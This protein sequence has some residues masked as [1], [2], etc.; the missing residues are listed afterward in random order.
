[1]YSVAEERFNIASHATGLVL[2]V[3]GLVFLLAQSSNFDDVRYV[4]SCAI[5]GLSLVALYAAST[6]YHSTS[7][8]EKRRRRRVVDHA[9]IYLLIAGTYTPFTLI[10]LEGPVGNTM[11]TVA[12]T[13]AFFGIGLKLI[14]T[15]R[16]KL[17][18][19]L[20]YVLMGWLMV[21][22][23]DP[24]IENLPRN[25]L[26]WLAAG[27]IAYTLGAV[28]YSFERI[29]YSHA[30]FHIFVLLGSASHFISVYYYVLPQTG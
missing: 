11:F 4:F 9:A 27:G 25:G 20:M 14:Y 3:I 2:S 5:F 16:F 10:T 23:I 7:E 22:A 30:I 12:W 13:M 28:L 21:F 6:W 8:P 29:H 15:G 24:L 26:L 19:T 18:S 17:L 1:M